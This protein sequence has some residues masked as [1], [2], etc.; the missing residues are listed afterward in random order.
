MKSFLKAL[1]MSVLVL[2]SLAHAPKAE[3]FPLMCYIYARMIDS[4]VATGPMY[5]YFNRN[6]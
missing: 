4:G 3:A 1:C 5:D 2:G 6:C